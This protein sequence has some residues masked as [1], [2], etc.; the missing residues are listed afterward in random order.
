MTRY[1]FSVNDCYHAYI[2]VIVAC[3]YSLVLSV[4]KTTLSLPVSLVSFEIFHVGISVA[5]NI[6]YRFSL[7]QTTNNKSATIGSND[8]TS[9][10]VFTLNVDYHQLKYDS[11][12]H[13]PFNF[14]QLWLCSH[15]RKFKYNRQ[16]DIA[17]GDKMAPYRVAATIII[18][19]LEARREP[20]IASEN[21]RH[22]I[23]IR[24]FVCSY[25]TTWA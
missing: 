21:R 22:Q 16:G 2:K 25:T 10:P 9:K 18:T 8:T 4:I 1:D 6:F 14:I 23:A 12:Y 15:L 7:N 20:R 11:G 24:S 17:V 5:L 19:M 3:H 13:T